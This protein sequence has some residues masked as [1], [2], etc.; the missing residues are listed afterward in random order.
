M[1]KLFKSRWFM[2]LI[3]FLIALMLYTVVTSEQ[4]SQA[5]TPFFSD[6]GE[7]I[8][9]SSEELSAEYDKDKYVVLGLPEEVKLQVKGSPEQ[10]QTT[11][12]RIT[13]HVFVDLEGKGPGTYKVPIQSEGLQNGLNVNII[14]SSV[15]VTIQKKVTESFPVNIDFINEQKLA[16]GYQLGDPTIEPETV[17]VT[18]GKQVIDSISYIKGVINVKGANEDISRELNLKAYDDNGNQLDVQMNPSSAD[19]EIPLLSPSKTMNVKT[20]T[21]GQLPD[22]TSLSSITVSPKK[23]DI[24]GEKDVISDINHLSTVKVPLD[25]VTEGQ[26]LDV[27][28][29]M[30]KGVDMVKPETVQVKVD[31]GQSQ[32]HSFKQVSIGVRGL[33]KDQTV[34]FLDPPDRAV[35]VTL[36]GTEQVLS[37]VRRGDFQVYVDVS[38]LKAGKHQ[39]ELQVETPDYVKAIV[40]KENTKIKVNS[41]SQSD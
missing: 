25:G 5:N 6:N 12:F 22:G 19:V 29:P 17:E 2:K 24:Y 8:E 40:S 41:E 33:D 3:A 36:E 30:P 1:D 11:K 7:A 27:D 37:S 21:K 9:T 28:V 4:D 15:R 20:E 14:P 34:E 16:A 13:K 26:T 18:G 31:V 38:D 39:A 23:V 10:V 35:D 32:K